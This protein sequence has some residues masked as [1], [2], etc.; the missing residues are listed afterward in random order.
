[1]FKHLHIVACSPRSGTTLLHEVMVTC[2]KVD[3]HYDHELRFNLVKAKAGQIVIT[4][5]PKDTMYMPA[6]IDDPELYV[7]YLLRDPRDVIVSRHGKD[8]GMYYS[9]IRLWRE[10]QSYA[11]EIADHPRFLQ[12]RYEDFV[13]RPDA[14]QEKIATRFPWLQK[15]HD[16][17][18]YHKHAVVSEKSKLAMNEVRPI[19]PSSVGK[20][21]TNLPRIKA[22]QLTHG[23]LTPDLIACGYETSADWEKML[24]GVEPDYSRSRYPEKVFFWSRL[25]QRINALRKVASYRRTRRLRC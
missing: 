14:A 8:K 5:R 13:S 22:Q 11:R 1:M 9:N 24:D 15:L 19:A 25:S 17:S 23:S 16:F 20:W 7:I 21:K 4:K 10:L 2:F 18:E 6:V 3:K 12:I